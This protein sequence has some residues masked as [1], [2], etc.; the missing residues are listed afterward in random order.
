MIPTSMALTPVGA[1]G[2]GDA[3]VQTLKL[4]IE[5]A[6]ADGLAGLVV[7]QDLPRGGGE[8]GYAFRKGQVLTAADLPALRAVDREVVHLV[9]PEPGDLGEDEAGL[10][11]ARAVAGDGL[12]IKGPSQSRYN[13]IAERRG[14]LR[15]DVAALNAINAVYGMAVFTLF[16]RQPVDEGEVVAG[17]KIAPLVIDAASIEAAERLAAAGPVIRV[18]PYRPARIATLYR[19]KLAP[20]ARDRFGEAVRQKAAW[21]GAEA[22]EIA[23]V[24]D[25]PAEVAAL[26]RRF[27]DEGADLIFAAGGSSTDPLDATIVALGLAGAR[28][29]RRGVPV[30]PGS[31]FW[32]AYLDETPVLSLASCSLFSQATIV[33]LLLPRALTGEVVTAADLAEIGHGGLMERGMEWRFPPYARAEGKR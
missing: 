18:A 21:F 3:G 31:M 19:E 2:E 8:K 27:V 23:P 24:S 30:H 11:L 10:R 33:D 17:A 26:L 32:M 14:L 25:E 12:T 9:R 13:L 1:T 22:A 15:V 16:D 5:E 7:A 6:T 20:A 4:R 29:V 28:L